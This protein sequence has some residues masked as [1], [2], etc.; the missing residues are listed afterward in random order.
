MLYTNVKLYGNEYINHDRAYSYFDFLSFKQD[1]TIHTWK[2]L[3]FNK[4]TNSNN[5][6][7]ET[8]KI[9]RFENILW[10]T[11]FMKQNNKKKIRFNSNI[12]YI[13]NLYGPIV[14]LT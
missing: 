3:V 1:I 10:R 7:N 8:N 11:W 6:K 9:K 14:L 2:N 4:N 12:N 5:N 13:N